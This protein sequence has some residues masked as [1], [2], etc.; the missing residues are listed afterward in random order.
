MS[1]K[2]RLSRHDDRPGSALSLWYLWNLV[3]VTEELDGEDEAFTNEMW[4]HYVHQIARE[5]ERPDGIPDLSSPLGPVE[6]DDGT[7]AAGA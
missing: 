5:S 6:P 1:G 2:K 7:P 4:R 3:G